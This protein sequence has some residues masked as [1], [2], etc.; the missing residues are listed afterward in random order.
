VR[1]LVAIA[2]HRAW[3]ALKTSGSRPFRREVWL[4]ASARGMIVRGYDPT[5][6]DREALAK[7]QSARGRSDDRTKDSDVT[8]GSA[9]ASND[10]A[11]ASASSAAAR[12][13]HERNSQERRPIAGLDTEQI[14]SRS[15]VRSGSERDPNRAAAYSHL[16]VLDRVLR[17]AFPRDEAAREAVL[18]TARE[19]LRVHLQDGR[20]FRHAEYA[21]PVRDRVETSERSAQRVAQNDRQRR[22]VRERDR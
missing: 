17:R 19:R 16:A 9:R 11:R 1:D 14:P 15:A 20:I 5:D 10:T 12:T 13:V 2:E 4:E 8:R 7:R 6:V 21:V 22:P 18:E 3:T